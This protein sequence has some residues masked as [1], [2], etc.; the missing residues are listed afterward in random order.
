MIN[1]EIITGNLRSWHDQQWNKK[2]Q[3]VVWD[4]QQ[5]NENNFRG[6]Y[7]HYWTNRQSWGLA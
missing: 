7:N 4:D 3:L 1:N 2:R 5:C 6:W